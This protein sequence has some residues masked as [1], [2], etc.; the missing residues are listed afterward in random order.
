MDARPRPLLYVGT[1]DAACVTVRDYFGPSAKAM[2][3]RR[4]IATAAEPL[5]GGRLQEPG[6]QPPR[7]HSPSMSRPRIGEERALIRRLTV[8]MDRPGVQDDQV[9]R[10]LAAARDGDERSFRRLY[11]AYKGVVYR[12]V[13]RIVGSDDAVDVSQDVFITFYRKLDRFDGRSALK[14]WLYRLTVNVCYDHLRKKRRRSAY[15]GGS[16]DDDERL[17]D[18]GRTYASTE[19]PQVGLLREDVQGHVD[20]AMRELAPELRAALI[21]KD[22]EDLSYRDIAEIQSCSEGTVASRLARARRKVAERL[23]SAGIDAAYFE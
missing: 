7:L 14:T 17:A 23:Q 2:I 6:R 18:G 5:P 10:L 21:L 16:I 4:H 11:D 12:M 15:D 9:E 20:D 8:Y 3:G 22:V 19:A 1:N 13:R